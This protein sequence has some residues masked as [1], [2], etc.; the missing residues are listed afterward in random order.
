MNNSFRDRVENPEERPTGKSTRKEGRKDPE[1]EAEA[2][3]TKRSFEEGAAD[4]RLIRGDQLAM[5][6][7]RQS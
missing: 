5:S 3:L 7:G 4:S 2:Q 6:G 1:G